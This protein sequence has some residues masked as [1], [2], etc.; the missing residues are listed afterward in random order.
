MVAPGLVLGPADGDFGRLIEDLAVSFGMGL[1]LRAVEHLLEHPRHRDN[2]RRSCERQLL[3]KV[4]DVGRERE[5]DA[6]LN[7][8]EGDD[9]GTTC[10]PTART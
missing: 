1:L 5:F 6:P 7:P 4:R 3:L 2:H 10:G 8:D 9:L